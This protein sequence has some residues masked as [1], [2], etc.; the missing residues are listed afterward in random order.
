MTKEQIAL[1]LLKL[2][3]KKYK[4]NKEM[5]YDYLDILDKLERNTNV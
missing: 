4:T 2:K 1:D 5:L 3:N